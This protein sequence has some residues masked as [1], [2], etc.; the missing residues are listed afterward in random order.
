MVVKWGGCG[1]CLFLKRKYHH[2]NELV[3]TMGEGCM[4]IPSFKGNFLIVSVPL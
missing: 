2:K 3:V 1:I 4:G